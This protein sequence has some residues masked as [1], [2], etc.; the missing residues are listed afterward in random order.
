MPRKKKPRGTRGRQRRAGRS[1]SPTPARVRK[2]KRAA[3][4]PK[5]RTAS[6]DP[7]LTGAVKGILHKRGA[8]R[9]NG[10]GLYRVRF[11]QRLRTVFFTYAKGTLD[12]WKRPFR[13]S[14]QVSDIDEAAMREFQRMF[15]RPLYPEG[16]DSSSEEESS[17]D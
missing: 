7:V 4:A 9:R 1:A 8:R 14:I 16:D 12:Q 3:T 5:R 15:K 17:D 10:K 11:R 13:K 6:A 2:Q